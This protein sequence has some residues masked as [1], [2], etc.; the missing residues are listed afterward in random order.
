MNDVL[1]LLDITEILNALDS[2]RGLYQDG[3]PSEM[4]AKDVTHFD[5]N[6]ESKNINNENVKCKTSWGN[7]NSNI[8]II[9]DLLDTFFSDDSEFL[10]NIIQN[11][12]KLTEKDIY[13]LKVSDDDFEDLS[14]FKYILCLG[15]NLKNILELKLNTKLNFSSIN[16]QSGPKIMPTYSIT[17]VYNDRNIKRLFWNDLQEFLKSIS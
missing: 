9:G 14:I 10:K 13:F 15:D 17:Q 11:G 12:M 3:I 5:K 6:N 4:L 8:L 7:K 16:E 1:D 2:V